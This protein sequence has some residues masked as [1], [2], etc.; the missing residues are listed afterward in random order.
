MLNGSPIYFIFFFQSNRAIRQGDPLLLYIF[1]LVIE[2]WSVYMDIALASGSFASIRRDSCNY[3]THLLFVDDMLAF[4]KANK[5]SLKD[6]KSMLKKLG[7]N[8]T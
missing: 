4:A 8:V 3:V 2:Y 6:L 5:S 1:V 7:L